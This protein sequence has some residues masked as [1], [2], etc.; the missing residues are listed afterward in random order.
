MK[1]IHGLKVLE[2]HDFDTWCPSFYATA[3]KSDVSDQ[4]AFLNTR[5]IAV[6]LW[7]AGWMPTYA[8]EARSVD[9]SNRGVTKHIV[10]WSHKDYVLDGERIELVGVNSHNRAS[11]FIFMAG[12]FRMVCA[13]GIISQTSDFGSFRVIHKGDIVEQVQEAITGISDI[14][15]KLSGKISEFKEI[16]LT[17][18]EQDIFAHTAHSFIYQ[19]PASAPITPD[20][21]L[22]PRRY[23]DAYDINAWGYDNRP[24]EDLWTT[25]N[26]IQENPLKGGL[27]GVNSKGSH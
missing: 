11:A 16:E 17:P 20:Q 18:N 9:L 27:R 12:I 24:K 4:Y 10:R 21:L 19:D 13:N 6:Q 15:G 1:I 26:V 2:T 14:A 22:K 25:F 8:R 7:K 23:A 5:D 3:P